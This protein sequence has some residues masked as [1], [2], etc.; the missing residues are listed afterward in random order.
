M[1]SLLTYIFKSLVNPEKL[2]LEVFHTLKASS[3][4]KPL[5]VIFVTLNAS[6]NA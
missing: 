4:G 1:G 6:G 2:G 3:E 5:A